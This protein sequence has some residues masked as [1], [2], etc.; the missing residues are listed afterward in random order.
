[1]KEMKK[2]ELKTGMW[3]EV[4]QKFTNVTLINMGMVLLDTENGDIIV[5]ETWMPLD[6]LNEDLEYE[7]CHVKITKIYQPSNNIDYLRKESPFNFKFRENELVW[8]RK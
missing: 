4:E 3:L 6:S 7:N 1:V 8:E 2:S 5:G